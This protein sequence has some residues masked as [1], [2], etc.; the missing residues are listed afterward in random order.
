MGRHNHITRAADAHRLGGPSGVRARSYPHADG[1]RPGPG[2]GARAKPPEATRARAKAKS[3]PRSLAKRSPG[4]NPVSAVI[5]RARTTAGLT[6]HQ[7]A[8]RLKTDSTASASSRRSR[9][10]KA[11]NG[12][13]IADTAEPDW[14]L[15]SRHRRPEGI[16]PLASSPSPVS[17]ARRWQISAHTSTCFRW[18]QRPVDAR[19]HPPPGHVRRAIPRAPQ[20]PFPRRRVATQALERQA[21]ARKVNRCHAQ[22]RCENRKAAHDCEIDFKSPN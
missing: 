9:R 21:V 10:G 18:N 7:L 15:P 13:S 5:V 17:M 4:D 22:Q 3:S 16:C 19:A 1:R 14:R 11:M 2:R 20:Q 12:L 6:Q 8:E